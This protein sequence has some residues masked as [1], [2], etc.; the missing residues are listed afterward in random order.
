MEIPGIGFYNDIDYYIFTE[1]VFFW[2]AYP[3]AR[4][5]ISPKSR[6]SWKTGETLWGD[7]GRAICNQDQ[8][9]GTKYFGERFRM[10]EIKE[11][12]T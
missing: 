7:V 4:R 1:L 10:D 8:A 3:A 5:R 12:L 11:T 2:M 9:L 6:K